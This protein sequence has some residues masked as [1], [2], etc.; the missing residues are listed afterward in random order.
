[1]T[2][3]LWSV[4]G[5]A[6]LVYPTF[7]ELGVVAFGLAHCYYIRAL[8]FQPLNVTGGIVLYSSVGVYLGL[9]VIPRLPDLLS[10]IGMPLYF[11]LLTTTAWRALAR[12]WGSPAEPWRG[13]G[14]KYLTAIG[15]VLFVISD[16]L[17]VYNLFVQPLRAQQF[18]I[19]STYYAAQFLISLS[20]NQAISEATIYTGKLA[21]EYFK[22]Y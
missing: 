8:G 12:A 14:A 11:T 13:A 5:D 21:D 19:M 20:A 16:C 17:I 3:L 10:L 15:A 22:G 4:V 2:G 7:F 9:V 1:M 6:C 18:L